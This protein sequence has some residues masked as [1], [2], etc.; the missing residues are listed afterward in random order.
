VKILVDENI[1]SR[2][3]QT[4]PKHEVA[5]VVAIGWKGIKNGQL[6]AKVADAGFQVF[7]TADKGM[8]FQQSIKGR[9][10]SLVVLDIHPNN[11]ANQTACILF[12]EEKI[13]VA[14]PGEVHVVEGPHPRRRP[15]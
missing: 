1:D 14:R 5:H 10:F 7:V 8:P 2:F 3:P 12:I 15:E 4:M 11:F 6:L 13:L 9:S